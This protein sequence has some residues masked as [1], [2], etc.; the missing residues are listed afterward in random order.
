MA[1]VPWGVSPDDHAAAIA[2]HT[3]EGLETICLAQRRPKNPWIGLDSWAI[4]E[5]TKGAMAMLQAADRRRPRHL[6]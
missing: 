1:P 5:A 6:M 2:E 4:H 3:R